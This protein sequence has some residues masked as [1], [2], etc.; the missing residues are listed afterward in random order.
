LENI[1]SQKEYKF[2]L[3]RESKDELLLYAV[4]FEKNKSDPVHQLFTIKKDTIKKIEI[5]DNSFI[6]KFK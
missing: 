5:L 6:F 1:D 3:L 4:F 2:W